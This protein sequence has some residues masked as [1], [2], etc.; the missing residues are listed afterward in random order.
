[1]AKPEQSPVGQSVSNIPLRERDTSARATDDDRAR[2]AL[3]RL[4]NREPGN[5]RAWLELASLSKNPRQERSCLRQVLRVNP[6][7]RQAIGRLRQL[8]AELAAPGSTHRVPSAK[9]LLSL[10][11]SQAHLLIPWLSIWL[12]M[13]AMIIVLG[14]FVV[15]AWGLKGSSTS[16]VI[17][18]PTPSPRPSPTATSTATPTPSV[19]QRAA[20]QIPDLEQ[21]WQARDWK[22]AASLLNGIYVLDGNYPGLHTAR[23]DTYLHWASDLTERGHVKQAYALYRQ[24]YS[25]CEDVTVVQARKSLALQYLSGKW[26]HD[27]EHWNRAATTLQGVYDVNPDYAETRSLLYT[28]YLAWSQAL[29]AEDRL[30]PAREA[31]EAALALKPEDPQAT[32]LL[33]EIRAKLVPTPTPTPPGSLR[34]RIEINIS[35]QR[36]YVW[37]GDILLYKWVCSTGEPGRGTAPG[38]YRVLG[39]IPEAWAST[40]RL[41][42]PYWLGIHYSGSL[43]NGI[44]ALPILPNGYTLWAGYLGTRISYGCIVLSTENARTLY[45]WADIGTPVWIHY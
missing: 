38:H 8:D 18:E 26:K 37:Q 16:P 11:R 42:M 27:H 45:H 12:L 3:T 41:R 29:V 9:A 24:A 32:A 39:K 20:E 1:M 35:Q 6:R 2:Y 7:N 31:C 28:S 15:Q 5:G 19:P 33:K 34:K 43:E 14:G 13:V 23:C 22:T 4:V 30:R 44:H 10:S 25:V 17:Y 21:A 40:W 36:M